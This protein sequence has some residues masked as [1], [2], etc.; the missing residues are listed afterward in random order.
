MGT[1][2]RMASELDTPARRAGLTVARDVTVVVPARNAE[3]L[4]EANLGSIVR[5]GPRELILV[6]GDSSDGTVALARGHGARILS[7]EGR[8]LPV[9]RRL[10][11][12][13]AG[14]RLVALIDADIVLGDGALERLL[15]EYEAGGY[16]AL[17]AGLH[18]VGGP[19]YWGQALAHHHRTGRSR[20]WFGL[21]ATIF[22]RTALLEHGFDERFSSGEDI[23]LRYRLEQAGERIGV[24]TRAVVEHR[25]EDGFPF[26]RG[27]WLADGEGHGRMARNH[28]GR[29]LLLL[30]VPVA[31]GLRGIALS[32]LRREPRWVPYFLCFVAYN[33]VGIAR[34]L[35]SN[36]SGRASP[37]SLG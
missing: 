31:A 5:A 22:D 27:Q 21:V 33:Y 3:G 4:L 24:S 10:G 35:R 19:G 20:A 28:G 15:E 32:A 11:A 1:N 6:D 2:P 26:A 29:A 18:S 23:D 17:Q 8:G 9:A 30:G 34:G 36:L 14:T 16:T 7:D 12:E 25:F 37:S 13:A